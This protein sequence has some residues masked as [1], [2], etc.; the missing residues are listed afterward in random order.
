MREII[1]YII[2]IL[3]YLNINNYERYTLEII[4]SINKYYGNL[5][6]KSLVQEYSSLIIFELEK[7]KSKYFKNRN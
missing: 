7:S 3:Q 1:E 2:A 6:F 4:E 5:V